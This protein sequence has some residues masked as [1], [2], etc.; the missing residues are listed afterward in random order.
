MLPW[1][2]TTWDPQAKSSGE[3]N[4]Y[5]FWFFWE[6]RRG[7][8]IR[9]TGEGHQADRRDQQTGDMHQFGAPIL[10]Y[11]HQPEGDA[12]GDDVVRPVDQPGMGDRSLIGAAVGVGGAEGRFSYRQ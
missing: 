10:R 5:G 2:R 3:A 4:T 6:N 1:L 12:E 8:E 7:R 9:D 11:R